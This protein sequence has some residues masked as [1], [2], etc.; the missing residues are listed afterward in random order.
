MTGLRDL[1]GLHSTR[2]CSA[3]GDTVKAGRQRALYGGSR[4]Q[5]TAKSRFHQAALGVPRSSCRQSSRA[6][7]GVV[8]KIRGYSF[9]REKSLEADAEKA[10]GAQKEHLAHVDV[11]LIFPCEESRADF[12]GRFNAALAAGTRDQVR[13]RTHAPNKDSATPNPITY[14]AIDE[15]RPFCEYSLDRALAALPR[16]FG[17]SQREASNG[18]PRHDHFTHIPPLRQE[19]SQRGPVPS[20]EYASSPFPTCLTLP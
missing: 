17:N 14:R 11:R 1:A 10:K 2:P 16:G 19:V 18:L 4:I 15:V 6:I 5:A 3:A 8:C 12:S 9:K 13:S 7:A 20:M